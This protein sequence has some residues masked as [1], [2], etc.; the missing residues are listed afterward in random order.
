MDKRLVLLAPDD[1]CVV[2]AQSLPA[3]AKVE[4]DG[5]GFAVGSR[6]PRPSVA[7]FGTHDLLP[8]QGWWAA[9]AGDSEGAAMA[10]AVKLDAQRARVPAERSAAVH[11]FLGQSESAIAVAQYDDLAG[12]TMPVNVPGTTTEHPN[13]R[14]RTA[15]TVGAVFE[16]PEGARGIEA[17]AAGRKPPTELSPTP[18][19]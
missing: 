1:N 10:A 7:T 15:R 17:I 11:A 8:L 4:I 2:V 5:A 14:R 18:K 3:G 19:G 6:Y 13:W 9:H 16:A 12:E